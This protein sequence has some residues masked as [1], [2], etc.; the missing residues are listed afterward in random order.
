MKTVSKKAVIAS[1]IKSIGLLAGCAMADL[2]SGHTEHQGASA[3]A[4]MSDLISDNARFLED[5]RQDDG[6][7]GSQ[8]G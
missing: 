3:Y 8:G 1:T 2:H 6:V 5:E 7:V 4:R